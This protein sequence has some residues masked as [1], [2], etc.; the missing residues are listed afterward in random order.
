MYSRSMSIHVLKSMSERPLT[1]QMHVTPGLHQQALTLAVRVVEE[2]LGERRPRADQAHVSEQHVEELRELVDRQPTD[3]AADRRDPRVV[4]DLEDGTR[5]HV[6]LDMLEP[7][8]VRVAIH[9]AELQHAE[10]LPAATDTLL[11]VEDRTAGRDAHQ[12]RD[13]EQQWRQ[14][15]E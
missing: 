14:Y 2:L 8:V 13:R 1:C 10:R 6:Q 5:V 7:P 11:D 9:G 12:D 15:D 4:A 3:R